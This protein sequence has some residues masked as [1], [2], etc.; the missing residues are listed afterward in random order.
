MDAIKVIAFKTPAGVD[1][2]YEDI[3]VV[4][5]GLLR[6]DDP[7]FLATDKL[8]CHQ[9]ENKDNSGHRSASA[10]LLK[11]FV[12]NPQNTSRRT[13]LRMP[14][15]PLNGWDRTP[16]AF[17]LGGGFPLLPFSCKVGSQFRRGHVFRGPL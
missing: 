8:P 11:L 4:A 14:E 17:A 12:V 9:Y 13:L 10:S 7:L 6:G 2:C 3:T 16:D 1:V 15:V 5:N